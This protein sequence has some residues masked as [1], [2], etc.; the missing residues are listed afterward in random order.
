MLA[1]TTTATNDNGEDD[2]KASPP[3]SKA[4][5]TVTVCLV[6][7][8]EYSKVWDT[9]S[10]M[11]RKLKDPGYYRWPPHAN[12]LYPFLELDDNNDNSQILEQLHSAT[13][14]CPP[15]TVKLNSFGTF[16]G[17]QRG[18]LWLYP[19]SPPQHQQQQ[20]HTDDDEP[21]K[22]LHERLEAAFPMCKDQTKQG[23]F[24]PHMTLSHFETLDDALAAQES[25]ELDYP[26]LQLDFL[27]DRIYLL[28]RKG[29]DGQFLRVAEVGLG[30]ES[31]IQIFDPP[32]AFPHM[33]TEEDEW[34]NEERMMLK[35][36]RNGRN[37]RGGWRHRRRRSR[38][39]RVPD[40]PEVIAAKRAERRVK[41]ER[42]EQERAMQEG[43]ED[44]KAEVD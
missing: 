10:E 25:M 36:R 1:A 7:P 18:V 29:D 26:N 13:R 40:A 11:R 37:G 43:L 23:K 22:T 3:P 12:L 31:T 2:G 44:R 41:R 42:L 34:V 16:G 17:K 5:H 8:P 30:P 33:P 32:Q 4:V 28:Q 20:Q 27:L 14:Q 19:D 9:V 39:L 21:L 35:A 6:P 38:E 15:F 24:S